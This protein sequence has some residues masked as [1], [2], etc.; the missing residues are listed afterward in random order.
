MAQEVRYLRSPSLI[1]LLMPEM[2]M[3]PDRVI[4][5]ACAI[6]S[7]ALSLL[8]MGPVAS[9]SP[10][11]AQQP[12]APSRPIPIRVADTSQVQVIRLGGEVLVFEL[13]SR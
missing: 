2:H 3:C 11:G 10:L 1:R 9:L 4:R 5:V 12:A 6:A 13:A 8:V 7:I